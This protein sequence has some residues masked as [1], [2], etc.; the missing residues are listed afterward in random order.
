MHWRQIDS[1]TLE[2]TGGIVIKRQKINIINYA[3][4]QKILTIYM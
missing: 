1:K 3:D 2:A 4:G